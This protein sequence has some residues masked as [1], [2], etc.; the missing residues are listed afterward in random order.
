MM[1]FGVFPWFE[2]YISI[3][4]PV[5]TVQSRCLHARRTLPV[6]HKVPHLHVV[7]TCACRN[8]LLYM[9]YYFQ[10]H[11]LVQALSMLNLVM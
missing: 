11:R 10:V 5:Y 9:Q 7:L 6:V 1:S 2:M 3:A 4:M 8:I